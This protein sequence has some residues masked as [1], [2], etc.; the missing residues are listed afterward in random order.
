M[1]ASWEWL[2]EGVYC[3]LVVRSV[4]ESRWDDLQAG[5]V[6]LCREVLDAAERRHAAK[7]ASRAPA[8]GHSMTLVACQGHAGCC[9]GVCS[10]D[11]T[12]AG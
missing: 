4:R 3:D 5:R 8:H 10:E 9:A 11:T 1:N 6:C 7:R 2:C 12:I